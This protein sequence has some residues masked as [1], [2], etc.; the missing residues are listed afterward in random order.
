MGELYMYYGRLQPAIFEFRKAV[1]LE[2]KNSYYHY[3]LGDACAQ[4][5]NLAEGITE[6]EASVRFK[7]QDGFYHFWLGDMLV[8]AGRNT[9]AVREMQQATIFSPVD[10]YYNV[11]LGAQY[12]RMLQFRDAAVA[13]RQAVRLAPQNTAYHCLLADLYSELRLDKHAVFHYQRAG[14]LDAFD[15]E[16]LKRL[17]RHAGIED[18]S[19]WEEPE[20]LNLLMPRMEPSG[21]VTNH[22]SDPDED[23]S[24]EERD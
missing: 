19:E 21:D 9:E 5:G 3:K 7:P 12:R 11:R 2:P 16:Q 6:L 18:D 1:A 23:Q 4:A 13:V 10:A 17:R 14:V 24:D 15:V 22:T 20:D 8:R